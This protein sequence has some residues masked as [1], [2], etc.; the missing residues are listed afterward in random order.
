MKILSNKM[1]MAIVVII[2]GILIIAFPS[3]I[4]WVIGVLLI[5]YG[6]LMLL[7]KK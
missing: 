6:V 5:A 1:V 2:A 3:F 4:R 7:S